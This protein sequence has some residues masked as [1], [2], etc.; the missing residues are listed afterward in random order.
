MRATIT[1]FILALLLSGCNSV[2]RNQKLIAGGNYQEA[3]YLAAK[4]ISNDRNAAKSDEHKILLQE[5][6]NKV[7]D[8][9]L[10]RIRNLKKENTLSSKRSVYY[11]YSQL[12]N[13]QEAIRPL[14]PLVISRNGKTL[15]MN[16]ADYSAD[17][18]QAKST[19]ADALY[20]VSEKLLYTEKKLDARKAYNYLSELD[21]LRPNDPSVGNM[22]DEARFRGT[23]FVFVTLNNRS[24]KIIPKPLER[25]LLD[26][27]TYGLDDFWTEY[28]SERITGYQYDYGVAL[29]FRLINFTPERIAER[30]ERRTK[31]IVDG[32][33]YKTDI[34]GN[35]VKDENGDPVKVDV[36]KTVSAM[37]RITQQSK[38]AYVE[39]NVVYRDLVNRRDL[40]SFPLATEFIFENAFASFMGDERALSPDDETLVDNAFIPFPPNGQMLLDAG[41]DIKGRLKTILNDN[42]LY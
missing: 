16:L 31:R 1:L 24:N 38:A 21:D 28:H 10:R 35:V 23:D 9:E 37:M 19:Y 14:L 42:S 8:R 25:E 30:E 12:E 41:Q 2:K 3:I 6:F 34:D 18:L 26:F 39:G 33:E 22:L 40:N 11:A 20:S 27:N 29:N 32:W 7:T 5:A 4:K 15:K 36:Y 17:L 13:I